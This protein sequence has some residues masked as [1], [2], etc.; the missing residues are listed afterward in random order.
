MG[1]TILHAIEPVAWLILAFG[2]APLSWQAFRHIIASGQ[3]RWL[4]AVLTVALVLRFVVP[5]TTI[6]WH[7]PL[8]N[9]ELSTQLY[10][11][12]FTYLPLS[13]WVIGFKLGA[14]FNGLLAY[15]LIISTLSIGLLWYAALAAGQRPRAAA[16]FALLLAITPMYVRYSVSDGQHTTVLFLY[17]VT[18][19]A[20]V[21]HSERHVSWWVLPV[22]FAAVVLGMPIRAESAALFLSAPLFYS[23][24]DLRRED[25]RKMRVALAVLLIAVGLG[26]LEAASIHQEATSRLRL[27]LFSILLGIVIRTSCLIAPLFPSFF[28]L[29]LAIP[30]WLLT[31][32]TIRARNWQRLASLYTPILFCAVPF[33]ASG[34]FIFVS[35]S[36]AG[37]NIVAA[38]FVLLASARG[39][40][41]LIDNWQPAPTDHSRRRRRIAAAI[42]APATAV[43]FWVGWFHTFTFMEEFRFLHEQMPREAAT[44]LT[45][46]DP[47]P[48][49]ADECC[50]AMPYGSL[51]AELPNTKWI[52]LSRS[53]LERPEAIRDLRFDYYYPGA[54][55]GLDP[56]NLMKWLE[57]RVGGDPSRRIEQ[58]TSLLALRRVDEIVRTS[59]PLTPFRSSTV[60]AHT[61]ASTGFPDNTTTLTIYQRTAP[62]GDNS[63]P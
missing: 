59:H 38:L 63:P 52:V 36:Q 47:D 3:R 50:L 14:G 62:P 34:Y 12:T 17:A 10:T 61:W 56:D 32:A 16:L 33:V 49:I 40:D 53:D 29:V 44:V 45:I 2:A 22:L 55:M 6:N 41:F 58:R 48:T 24:D 8:M 43:L 37:R 46:W 25:V 31:A 21:A 1:A 4:A 9:T 28:P 20:L 60:P 11:R 42:L 57:R 27:T 19:A 51:W 13:S 7:F 23:H 30:I 35:M 26:V 18:A 15:N 39:L 54:M 5:W